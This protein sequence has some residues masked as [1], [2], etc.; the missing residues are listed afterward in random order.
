KTMYARDKLRAERDGADVGGPFG[1]AAILAVFG[2][3]TYVATRRIPV[4]LAA[5]LI[6][7]AV[8]RE[9]ENYRLWRFRVERRLQHAALKDIHK[10]FIEEMPSDLHRHITS[11]VMKQ[12]NGRLVVVQ[13]KADAD[14]IV[15][16]VSDPQLAPAAVLGLSPETVLAVYDAR[17]P[18]R[19]A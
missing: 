10:I 7:W 13:D 5:V 3:S 14:V 17:K 4:T 2:Y 11:E 18:P 12:I 16:G 19:R 6:G 1:M 8:L 9:H 15:R